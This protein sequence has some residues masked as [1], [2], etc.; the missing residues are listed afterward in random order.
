MALRETRFFFAFLAGAI[1]VLL[2]SA[3]AAGQAEDEYEPIDSDACTTCHEENAHGSA[4]GEDLSHSVHDGLDCLSCHATKD[5]VPHKEDPPDY[6][7]GCAGCRTCHEDASEAYQSHG[8]AAIGEC[9]DIPHCSDCHG[10]HD[11]LPSSVKLSRTHP[12]NLP[13]TCGKCHEDLNITKK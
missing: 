12:V 3:P 1:V 13:A 5:T 8:R 6:D 7:V 11:V 9:D 10:D 2:V 4:M